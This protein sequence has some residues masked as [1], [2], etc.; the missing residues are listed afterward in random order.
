MLKGQ[1]VKVLMQRKSNH[2]LFLTIMLI[3]AEN[4]V[5]ISLVHAILFTV[6]L[7]QGTS[8]GLQT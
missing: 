6:I 8:M 1:V 3:N 4:V 5:T 7:L 2:D